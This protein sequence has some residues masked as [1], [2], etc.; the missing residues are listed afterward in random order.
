ME[1]IAE[2]QRSDP[3]LEI[4]ALVG[5][6]ILAS[7]LKRRL[8]ENGRTAANI[9]FHTF[10]DLVRRLAVAPDT[11][12]IKQPLP[13]LAAPI[14][15]ENILLDHVPPIYASLSRYKG[16]RDAL[17][18]TFRDLR[19]AG[20]SASDLDLAVRAIN[21]TQ[22]RRQQLMGLADLYRRFREQ[23][24]LY[25]DVDD[26]FRAAIKNVSES[27]APPGFRQLIVYG[28]YDATG[29][30]SRL[31]TALKGRL[32]VT[33]FIPY[34]DGAVSDFARPFLEI[35]AEELGVRPVHLK[36]PPPLN[37]LGRLAAREFGFS[38]DSGGGKPLPA[39]GT[40]AL[41]SVPG[42]S[43][44]AVEI[45][46]EIFRAV[47]DGTISGFHEAAVI[48][49]QPESD[50]PILAEMFRLYRVPYFIHGGGRFAER[51]LSQAVVALSGLEPD[52]FSREAILAAME[53]V[54]ASLPDAAASLWDVPSWRA[55]TNDPGFLSG[56]QSWD[57][58]TK[59]LLERASRDLKRA[60]AHLVDGIET[61]SGA[62]AP[63]IQMARRRLESARL[64]HDAWQLLRQAAA[65]WPAKL[66]W[67]DWARFLEERLARLL[68]NS[69]DWLLFT[70]VL[71]ELGSLQ[72][73]E[74]SEIQESEFR[75][76]NEVSCD[77]LRSALLESISSLAYPAGRFQRNGVNLLGISAARGIR[78]PLIII[79]GLDEGRFP[80]KLRQD[81]LLPDS[82][83]LRMMSLPVK[84]KRIDEERLLFDMAA[85]SAERRL[86]LLTSRLDESSDREKIP[87]QYFL[88]VAAAVH[89]SVVSTRDL[90]QGNIP[91]FRSVSL[92]RPAP[93]LDDIPVDEGEIRLRLITSDLVSSHS[94][95]QALEK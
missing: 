29:Q 59:A 2:L 24:S 21:K 53:L 12:P 19:D 60:E 51:P 48:L 63:S 79:P 88:R 77:R 84:S 41:V 17:L 58:G 92:D 22:E 20:F 40:F 94:A 25:H 62:N 26:D 7:Y 78:F 33:Y 87:S 27:C 65:D 55:M 35:R 9:R 72:P 93:M 83:R 10:L 5:S 67:Q 57:A 90:T 13:R 47:R 45:V 56:L 1:V 71:D 8:A 76:T 66:S 42:E 38:P 11:M 31:L 89:G 64:L 85:R 73:P 16:F 15:M 14:L 86:V 82:E 70:A 80:A 30:Q 95:L 3:L 39:D 91:G 52:C 49:R 23:M 6:N 69:S 81:P 36:P 32:E 43:R 74:K 68:G 44:A 34:V 37:N 75:Q 46:R 61:E 50:I 28:I 4:D 54:T 18:D